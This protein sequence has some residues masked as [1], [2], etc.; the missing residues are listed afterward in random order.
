MEGF[1]WLRKLRSSMG[2]SKADEPNPAWPEWYLRHFELTPN[3]PANETPLNELPIVIIDAKA[4][5]RN[6]KKDRLLRI[7]ALPAVGDHLQFADYFEGHLPTPPDQEGTRTL[8]TPDQQDF[9]YP[10]EEEL[11]KGLLAFIGNRPIVG[12]YISSDVEMINRALERLGAGPLRCLII[13][14]ADLAKRI[15]P[16]GYWSPSE[17]YSLNTLSE[18]Y[19]IS[20][21]ERPT[22]Q[23]DAPITGM[24]WL[25]LKGRLQEKVGRDLVVGDL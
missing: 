21:S 14:T 19:E 12:H 20:L 5:G 16:S 13:D 7:I 24:L 15:Q 17:K 9:K 4:T 6:V 8:S 25:K 3:K 22:T 1:K 18:H 23:G 2:K 11:M 10:D